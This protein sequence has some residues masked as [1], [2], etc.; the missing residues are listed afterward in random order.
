[1]KVSDW[2]WG[3]SYVSSSSDEEISSALTSLS[4]QD[5]ILHFSPPKAVPKAIV[6]TDKM[7]TRTIA[8]SQNSVSERFND[9]TLLD[10]TRSQLANREISPEQIPP[11]RVVLFNNQWVSLD[12]RR[13]RVFKDALIEQIPVIKCSLKDEDI[14]REFWAKKSKKLPEERGVVR[15]NVTSSSTEHF[16]KGIFVF[17]KEVLKWNLLEIQKSKLRYDVE[18]LPSAFSSREEYL[19]SFEAFIFEEVRAILQSGYEQMDEAPLLTLALKKK[20]EPPRNALNPGEIRF[21]ILKNEGQEFRAGEA[22]VL[23]HSVLKDLQ[24]IALANYSESELEFS[25]KIVVDQELYNPK[26]FA[27]DEKWYAKSIGSLITLQRMYE[28]CTTFKPRKETRLEKMIYYGLNV[29][30]YHSRPLLEEEEKLLSSLNPSQYQPVKEFL[31]M[32]KGLKMIQGPPGTGKTTTVAKLLSALVERGERVLVCAS[33]NKGAQTLAEIMLRECPYIPMILIGVEKKLPANGSLDG[34]F[35]DLWG[36]RRI[37]TLKDLGEDLWEFQLTELV[38]G[39]LKFIKNRV[40]EACKKLNEKIELLSGFVYEVSFLYKLTCFKDVEGAEREIENLLEVYSEYLHNFEDW[41]KIEEAP[42]D[43]TFSSALLSELASHFSSLQMKL[44][45]LAQDSSKNGLEMQLLNNS[46]LIFATLSTSGQQRLKNMLP[47]DSLIIDEAGQSLEA[48]T[49]IPLRAE[50]RKCLLVGDIQQLPA[51]IISNKAEKLKFG[52]SMMER[53]SKDCGIPSSMLTL[54]YRM[55]PAICS[56]PSQAFY[57]GKLECHPSVGNEPLALPKFLAPYSFIDIPGQERKGPGGCSYI[58]EA[59]IKAIQT[60]LAYLKEQNI[61]IDTRVGVITFY[62][63]QSDKIRTLFPQMT[64]NTVDGFQG[65]ECDIVLIS[66]V[67]ANPQNKI[68]FLDEYRRLNVALTRAKKSLIVLGNSEALN[69]SNLALLIADAKR[70]NLLHPSTVLQQLLP[71]KAPQIKKT[72]NTKINGIKPLN[73]LYKTD[74]CRHF[75]V[76]KPESCKFGEKCN[77]I[78]GQVKGIRK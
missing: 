37:Q 25:L 72:V 54:Q 55:D 40:R 16:E 60:I 51:T 64:V 48:E 77:F 5:R 27:A 10:D 76:G 3:G 4:F 9:G 15:S 62:K 17:N 30:S 20:F 73:P 12:N 29:S 38:K 52:R 28:S 14:S 8:F 58:N 56:F 46:R 53:L 6:P 21:K 18:K 42:E 41:E 57:E 50:P 45:T 44:E 34:I 71:K 59:E 74:L 19:G 67:R 39:D 47:V 23:Q 36:E 61:D 68:G 78:H 35:F 31:Q 2:F 1:M 22:F 66:C 26:A 33:S 49:T 11:I 70:R 75:K 65:G 63:A 69:K 32:E 7:Q 43:V 13:L 24:I